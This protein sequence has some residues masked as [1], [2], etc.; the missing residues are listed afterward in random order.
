ME[1]ENVWKPKKS[2]FYY[3]SFQVG[4]RRFSGSTRVTGRKEAVAFARRWKASEVEKLKA[5]GLARSREMTFLAAVDRYMEERGAFGTTARRYELAFDWLVP[6]VGE[7]TPLSS[8][9][10][11]MVARLVA[12]RGAMYRRGEARYGL[13]SPATV[14]VDVVNPLQAMLSRARDLWKVPLP[15]MPHWKR[16]R[17]R[18]AC[19]T[20]TM[21]VAEE[22]AVKAAAGELWPV[23]EFILLTGLRRR[24]ALVRWDQVDRVAKVIRVVAKGKKV[25]EVRIT[26]GIERLLD[27]A[28]GPNRHPRFVWCVTRRSRENMGRC[29]PVT[30]NGFLALF[31]TVLGRAGVKGLTLHDLRRTA[32]ERMY[33]ATGDIAAVS[34]FLGHSSIELTRRHYVHVVP[35][36]V[37]LR[38]LA[39]EHARTLLH[40]RA[41]EGGTVH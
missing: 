34:K 10:D 31:K 20:R 2:Q 33:R 3:T 21:S 5:A 39:M 38:Q 19:R 29:A 27:G 36:D 32:G 28:A 37:E 8:V 25:H 1:G 30:V 40:A 41:L 13:V 6:R 9:D 22:M 12:E 24:D 16:H 23:I 7:R 35:D 18:G 15:D 26:P 11:D 14:T 17:V 4:G